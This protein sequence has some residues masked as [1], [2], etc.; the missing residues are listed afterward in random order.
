[1]PWDK[2]I[3]QEEQ[4]TYAMAGLGGPGGFGRR[5]ALLVIDVQYRSVGDRPMP[6]REAIMQYPT[7]CGKEGWDAIAHIAVLIDVFRKNGW[8]VIYP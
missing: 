4:E 7:S 2:V 1:R 3:P 8:P 5:P 6:I